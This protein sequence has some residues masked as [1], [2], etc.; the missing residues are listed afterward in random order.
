MSPRRGVGEGLLTD[1]EDLYAGGA[2]CDADVA[3]GTARTP[4]EGVG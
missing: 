2:G 3:Y 4:L 1:G